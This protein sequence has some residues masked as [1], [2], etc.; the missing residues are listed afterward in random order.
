M[1]AS[2][3]VILGVPF[4]LTNYPIA[5]LP[6]SLKPILEQPLKLSKVF[7]IDTSEH[8]HILKREFKRSGFETKVPWRV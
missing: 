3:V 5:V 8:L 6:R 1:S 2:W 7:A 4:L